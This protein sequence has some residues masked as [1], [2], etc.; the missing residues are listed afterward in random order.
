[1]NLDPSTYPQILADY[2]YI[3]QIIGLLIIITIFSFFSVMTAFIAKTMEINFWEHTIATQYPII[4]Q[5]ITYAVALFRLIS[6]AFITVNISR[7]LFGNIEVLLLTV[8]AQSLVWMAV[9]YL[10]TEIII[11]LTYGPYRE[12]EN[13]SLSGR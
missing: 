11:V 4:A 8:V 7:F 3:E 1:M 5:G 12:P 9:I 6:F 13:A 2:L 10:L